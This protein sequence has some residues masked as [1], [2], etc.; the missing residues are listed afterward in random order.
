LDNIRD[1]LNVV[2]GPN[3]M[4]KST[5]LDA[6]RA[7]LFEKY[8]SK[9]QPIVDLQNDRNQAAPVVELTFELDDGLY[10][11][12]KRFLKKPHAHL[13]CPDGRTLE[14]DA[15]EDELRRL[16]GF[17]APGK[18]GAKAE[19]LG[20]WNVLWVQQG[21]SFGVLDLPDSA[22]SSLHGALE[23]EV[24][25]VLG[26]RRGRAL[27][28]AIERQLKELI[29]PNTSRARGKYKDLIDREK[30][31][32]ED[33]EAL[34]G[35]RRN[36]TQT[37]DDLESAEETLRRLSSAEA[38]SGEADRK[39]LAE[40]QKRHSRLTE[41]EA[42]ITAAH[43][44]L[45]LRDL[46]LEQ[47]EQAVDERQK[48][49][50]D[51]KVE[52]VSLGKTGQE[53][54]KVR[55]Q[56]REARSRLH[57]LR[58]DMLTSEKAVTE[59]EE[60]VS[61]HRRIVSVVE[62]RS[63]ISELEGRHRKAE[64]AEERQREA[65]RA[66]AAIPVTDEAIIAIREA[67]KELEKN[68]GRLSAAATLISFEM[69]SEG[70]RGIDVDGKSLVANRLPLRTVKPTTITI[71]ERGRIVVEPAIRN[72]DELI[73]QQRE[74]ETTLRQALKKAGVETVGDAEEQYAK[75]RQL[76][77]NAEFACREVEIQAPATDEHGAGAQALSDHIEG[78]RQALGR[79]MND[80]RLEEPPTLENAENA[81]RTAEERARETRDALTM[82]RAALSGP[83][84][85]IGALQTE[86]STLP[87]Q[88]DESEKRLAKLRDRL[89][90]EENTHPDE[91]LRVAVES[92]R[93]ALSEQKTA[94]A[95][96]EAQRT[97]ETL[98][99]LEARISRLEKAL[100]DRHGKRTTLK[101]KIAGLKARVEAAEGAGLDEAIEEKG[102]ELGL[103][104]EERR[105]MDREVKVLDLLRTTLRG[106]EQKAKERYLSPVLNRV[107]PYL[108]L[109]FPSADIRIDGDL[110][111][112]GVVREA[113]YEE[114]FNRLSMG[115]QEQI[116]V[117]VR[118][119]F[120][121]ML[122]EQGRP[123]TIVLDDALVFSD[124]RRM[125]RMFDI[126]NVAARNVQVVA[127]TCR[128]QLF[129][130]LGAHPLSL[131]AANVEELPSA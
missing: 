46:L 52:E 118:L 124:D 62:R 65:R 11:I 83:E 34:R 114:A 56:E 94:I 31:L 93:A 119:A 44:E 80:L 68:R 100:Q 8:D 29:T 27:P 77:D 111:I 40:A 131:T 71:P 108:T 5:L 2:V 109:L 22:Q 37:L 1:G 75:R 43:T 64:I 125:D 67:E 18:R 24:G 90:R 7:V 66:A 101:E 117:L 23:R 16:L 106:A 10:C 70:L 36:L 53:L 15:A 48:L 79:E 127:L 78:L 63:G 59:A 123:A 32:G 13:S 87:G 39:E 99:Q 73:H 76:L 91:D 81:L 25:D 82:A 72:R 120:A 17:D 84:E 107:R 86:F 19:T 69:T 128:E 47:A 126:L 130:R 102:R 115:T 112:T 55:E 57:E 121:Q 96:L 33:L 30:T 49:K 12:A 113:G 92:A 28:Q 42:H 38:E 4:G 103:C 20:L 58:D 21:Q 95:G 54:A 45:E 85:A 105:R 50:D 14:G 3:E 97:D 89:T 88:H 60:A 41:L 116:A 9:A 104:E 51:I 26:G 35:R 98:S 122:A 74:A 61:R 110:C 129:E 6:L